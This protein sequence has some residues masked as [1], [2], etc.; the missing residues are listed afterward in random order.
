VKYKIIR[1]ARAAHTCSLE[2][3]LIALQH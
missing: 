2:K 1:I 3:N